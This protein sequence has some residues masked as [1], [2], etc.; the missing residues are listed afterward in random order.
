MRQAIYLDCNASTPLRL[1]ARAAMGDALDVAGNPSSI[2]RYGRLARR[3]VEDA[4]ESVATLVG[5]TPRQVVF[6]SG[7]TEANNWALAGTKR[8]RVFAGATEHPSV[9]AAMPDAEILPVDGDGIVDLAMLERMLAQDR[10]P[11]LVSLMLANNE[12]GV[13]QPVAAAAKIAHAAGALLHCDAVQA[14]GRIEVDFGSLGADLMS[15]SS[16]KIG[17]PMGVGALVASDEIALLP[18]IRGGG[19]EFG[20]RAGTENVPAIAGFGAAARELVDGW[21]EEATTMAVLRDRLET[22][23]RQIV[24]AAT[25]IGGNMPRLPN[26]SCLAVTDI[27]ADLQVMALDLAGIAV[28]AGS[29]CSSGKVGRSHVLEAM[30][31]AHA[32][33]GSAIRVSLGWHSEAADIDRFVDAWATVVMRE[34]RQTAAAPAA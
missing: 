5:A 31:V 4:R 24:P 23:V 11:A 15:V 7:A 10:R 34:E 28:S 12:T 6:T 29:A 16:H 30:G 19:Q 2:H 1:K 25:V 27:A 8:A 17:G 22:S 14:V 32:L 26:T 21:R 20:R 33:A 13:V 9:L 18:A 3:A